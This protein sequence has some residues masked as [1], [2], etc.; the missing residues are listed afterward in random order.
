MSKNKLIAVVIFLI[1]AIGPFNY[2]MLQLMEPNLM[3][4]AMFLLTLV[5]IAI[6]AY[7]FSKRENHADQ[8]A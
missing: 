2:G 4:L 7:F 3:T 1:T 8:A 6:G 5:G